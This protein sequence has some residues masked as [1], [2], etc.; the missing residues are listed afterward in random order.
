MVTTS[1]APPAVVRE[2]TTQQALRTQRLR[3]RGVDVARG[4]AVIGMLFVDNRGSDAI[5]PQLIHTPWSGLHVADVVFPV[6][7]LV[8]GV[9]MPFSRR[10]DRPKA[11]LWR[12][13]KLTLLGWLIV[14]MKYG[15]GQRA[16]G[17]LGHIAGAYLLCWLLLRLPRRAQIPAAVGLLTAI[18]LL[19]LA[20]PV[21]G[22]GQPALTAD[23]SWAA[24]FDS[25]FGMPFG[26]E[27]PHAY[28]PSAVTVFIGVLAGRTLLAEPGQR[29]LRRLTVGGAALIAA[30][31]AVAP[32][33][34]V[35]KPLWTPSYVL[36]T[37][38]IGLLLLAL[39]HWLVDVR[40]LRRPLRAAEVL[41]VNA[42]VAFVFSEIVFRALLGRFQSPLV[43]WLGRLTSDDFAA[44][45]YPALSV[46]VI[47]GV[48]AALLRRGIVVR[49]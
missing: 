21:P 48:C 12:V 4:L 15:W 34:P 11:V 42:I 18:S 8:V 27:G 10:A 37:G 35:S 17:V 7:L 38:G 41:G 28:L 5:N 14:T 32:F 30:G 47:W 25:V 3:L 23:T 20:V 16:P 19:F 2:P 45:L 39:A 6:F 1:L 24:W 29:A 33:V 31:A 22:V 13:A 40:G 36:L 43:D 46:L 49:V 44:Y 26:A 9:T